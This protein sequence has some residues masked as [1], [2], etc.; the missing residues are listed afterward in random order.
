MGVYLVFYCFILLLQAATSQVVDQS[1]ALCNER[2]GD[3]TIPYPF[4]I[5]PGCYTNSWFRV[6]CNKT[7]N[8]QKP[9][10]HR[11]NL[12]LLNSS[13]GFVTVNNP[14]THL[15]CDSKANNGTTAPAESVDLKD[16]PFYFTI[17]YN[18]F[19]SVGCGNWATLFNNISNEAI[20]GCLQPGC[21]GDQTPKSGG[22][23]AELPEDLNISYTVSMKEII[24][25]GPGKL[26]HS[27]RSC[28]SAFIFSWF[29][30]N[31]SRPYLQHFDDISIDT[32]H[33]PAILQWNESVGCDWGDRP[34]GELER[35]PVAKV[36]HKYVCNEKCGEVD[37]LYPFGME[38]GCY[39]NKWFRLSC[40]KTSDGPKPFISS[41]SDLQ[42]LQ[43]SFLQGSVT[44]NNSITYSNC[45]N[46][47]EENN[48]VSVDLKDTPFYLSDISNRLFSV[49][50]GSFVTIFRNPTDYPLGGCLQ[51][52]CDS[53]IS[54]ASNVSC[55]T[56]I[57]PSLSSL[58]ANMTEF[59]PGNSS[60]RSCG[61]AFLADVSLGGSYW[62]S[63][64]NGITSW[65]KDPRTFERPQFEHVATALQWGV[66][67]RGLCELKDGLNTLCSSDG[68]YCWSNISSTHLCVCSVKDVLVFG[69][70]SS[71]LGN[72]FSIDVC[73][74]KR[75]CS[76]A[77][78]KYCYFLCLNDPGNYCNSSTCPDGYLYSSTEG[79]CK[80]IPS[81]QSPPK[82]P[83]ESQDSLIIIGCSASIGT[84]F[85]LIC[86]WRMF[87]VLKR[88]KSIK[89]KQKY[90]KR[91]GGL[92]L[93]QQLSSKEGNVEKIRFFASKELEKATDHY[94]VNRIIGQG[95]QGTVYKGMLADGSIVAIKKSK[96][97]EEKKVDEKKLQQFINEVIILSQ[98]NHRNVVKLLGCCL[99]TKVPLLVYEFIPNGTLTQL[100]HDQNEEFPM[101]WEMRSRIAIESASALSYLH[102]AA[103]VPIYHR[104]VKS[105]NI[106]LDDK[107]RTKVSDF[108]TSISVALEQTH[109]TTRVQGTFGYL[110]PEYF[111]SSQFTEKSDVYSFGVVL[112]ELLTGQ[113]PISSTQS[114][115]ARSLASYFLHS[116]KK[117][118]LF[119]ILDPTV[120]KD[121]PQEEI[122]AVAKLAKRCLNL[123]GKKRPTMKQVAVELEWIRLSE[124]AN[125]IQQKVDEDSDTDDE[126]EF[127]AI[128]SCSTS[129]SIIND[130]ITLSVDT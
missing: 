34:C 125:I 53:H 128:A 5:R 97:M 74:D 76:D 47:D 44:V 28:T 110:D 13:D 72:P 70:S 71:N 3:V 46:K 1:A 57:P 58:A 30:L 87:K 61:S 29:M 112:V 33:V 117:N 115:E 108:G 11:I 116:M 41:I 120:R 86:A 14:V 27:K 104:D 35:T 109:V 119:D 66:P 36:P 78:Y 26:Q 92:L 75:D 121:G 107:Y 22:C 89:L 18:M 6:V 113:K 25:P 77:E 32:T 31:S 124:E 37:I 51:P 98:I 127:S 69:S 83:K 16:C 68:Q 73:Q 96:M 48:L 8:G 7:S 38:E 40:N 105:S 52:R 130:S 62:R 19:G 79:L 103:S 2:C 129:R 88:R 106:L 102:S 67:K 99:E 24:N 12:E 93:Q 50:C 60:N 111:R 65:T 56:I 81:L 21:G 55:N 114:E 10:I 45:R 90:F 42:L 64:E 123:N 82:K 85:V 126:I 94:N 100:I 84:A 39:M 91:N 15:N 9:F 17:S 54:V 95:G 23:W 20:A 101:T 80:R 59:Y 43:V 118:S 49:G 63:L 122:I 4:G